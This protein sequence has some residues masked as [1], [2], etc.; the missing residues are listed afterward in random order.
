MPGVGGNASEDGTNIPFF[1]PTISLRCRCSQPLVG[2]MQSRSDADER[3]VQRIMDANAN[4]NRICIF[5]ARPKGNAIANIVKGGGYEDVAFYEDLDFEFLDIHNIHVMR[6]SLRKVKV[7]CFPTIDDKKFLSNIDNTEWLHHLKCILNGANRIVEK[8][9]NR[10]SVIVHCSD[11]WD[12]TAQLTS[13]SM[14]LL[15]PFYRTLEG[16][17]VLIEKEWLSFGHKFAHRIG[18][19]EDKHSNDRSVAI[20]HM[21]TLIN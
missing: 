17:Q 18:H 1:P 11:G 8:I 2:P 5:D 4:S 20:M 6:E 10:S 21:I 9:F 19:W 14:L 7:V 3:M 16:F 12:R 13:L 15:D